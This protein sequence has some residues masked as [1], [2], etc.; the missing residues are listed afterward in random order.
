VSLPEE[1]L[2][3]KST[4][5]TKIPIAPTPRETQEEILTVLI[6]I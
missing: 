3:E 6:K 2:Q 1:L 4:V 5:K